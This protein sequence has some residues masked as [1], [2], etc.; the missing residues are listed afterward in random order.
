M[1][2]RHATTSPTHGEKPRAVVVRA[3]GINA[4]EELARAFELAGASAELLHLDRA[5][6]DPSL[7]FNA[8]LIGFAGGFSYGDDIAG[9]R[10]FAARMRSKLGGVLAEIIDRGTPI[11]GICNGFQILVQLGAL[12]GATPSGTPRVALT[13]NAVP[14]YTDRWVGVRSNTRSKCLWTAGLEGDFVL[15][16]AHGE[17]RF[18]CDPESLQLLE[19]NGLVA[20]GYTENPNGSV[21]AEINGE[22]LGIAGITN[23]QGN[24]LGLMPH[25]ERFVDWLHHPQAT[26][27]G[28][29]SGVPSGLAMFEAAVRSVAGGVTA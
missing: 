7:L 6:A 24:V 20:L 1:V 25:P 29:Q 26:S 12:P 13:T 19:A 14:R 27:F 5:I 15:P 17:G 10:V 11:I 8:D 21:E 9:G 28:N 18:V 22:A 16:M 2:E 3:P 4:D 23:A